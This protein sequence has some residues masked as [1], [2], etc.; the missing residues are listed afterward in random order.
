[1]RELEWPGAKVMVTLI[2]QKRYDKLTYSPQKEE[3]GE[4]VAVEHLRYARIFKAGHMA[5][6]KKDPQ[7]RYMVY[8]FTGV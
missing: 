1:M 6:K 7:V 4:T 8:S 3:F 5:Q 2:D